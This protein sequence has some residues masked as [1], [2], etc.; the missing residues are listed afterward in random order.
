MV[1]EEVHTNANSQPHPSQL[2]AELL[3]TI[4]KLCS[5]YGLTLGGAPKIASVAK[6]LAAT[7]CERRISCLLKNHNWQESSQ[8]FDPLYRLKSEYAVLKILDQLKTKLIA[9]GLQVSIATEAEYDFGVSDIRITLAKSQGET[10]SRIVR[11]EVKAG[12]GISLEQLERYLWNESPLIVVRVMTRHVAVLKPVLLRRFIR[13]TMR[14]A[15]AKGKRLANGTFQELPGT[16]CGDCPDFGCSYN[17]C[18]HQ[19][20]K[21]MV[22]IRENEFESDLQSFFENIPLI[23]EKVADITINLLTESDS[24]VSETE[25]P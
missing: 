21:P 2:R 15:I 20:E 8:R 4:R 24:E 17:R 10:K 7:P 9:A 16:H 13:D 11:I 5:A 12:L 6:L 23:A 1:A 22:K 19:A 25:R 3:E 14:A 18:R